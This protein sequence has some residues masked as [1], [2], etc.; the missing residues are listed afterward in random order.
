MMRPS[1]KLMSFIAI[2]SAGLASMALFEMQRRA[3]KNLLAEED[4]RIS[5]GTINAPSKA[6]V[7]H[8]GGYC[9]GHTRVDRKSIGG[10]AVTLNASDSFLDPAYVAFFSDVEKSYGGLRGRWHTSTCQEKLDR[11]T[12]KKAVTLSKH[13][14]NRVL[15]TITEGISRHWQVAVIKCGGRSTGENISINYVMEPDGHT[16]SWGPG[17]LNPGA[18]P[19]DALAQKLTDAR[20]QLLELII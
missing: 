11:A 1:C 16:T 8:L 4:E 14:L 19:E 9:F 6:F 5:K 12:Y 3:A 10:V 7:S 17:V 2:L 18:C 13:E 15:V 20:D